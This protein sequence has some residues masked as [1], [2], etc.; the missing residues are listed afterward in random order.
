MQAGHDKDGGF[1]PT[2]DPAST[3]CILSTEGPEGAKRLHNTVLE[4]LRVAMAADP[5]TP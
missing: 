4:V 2:P 1:V 3:V 5:I